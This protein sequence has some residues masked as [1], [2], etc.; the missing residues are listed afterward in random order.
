MAAFQGKTVFFITHRLLTIR[1]ADIILM[2]DKGA[3]AEQGSHAELMAM[4]G[5]YYSLYCQQEA[6]ES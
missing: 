1:N 6:T 2:M 4:K 3:I 5:L